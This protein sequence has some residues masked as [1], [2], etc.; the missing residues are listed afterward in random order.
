MTTQTSEITLRH[1]IQ[2]VATGP[3]YSK[4]LNLEEAHLAMQ[5][6]LDDSVDP[7][8]AAVFL[9][10]LR[11]KRE[12]QDENR[13]ALQ[14]IRETMDII[15][16]PVET[17]LDIADPY[18]G[19]LRHLPMSPFLPAVLASC[20]IPTF[21]HG[22][23]RVGPKYGVTHAKILRAAGINSDRT[24]S[25]AAQLLNDVGWAYV[26]QSRFCPALYKLGSLRTRIVKRP[27]LT[28]IEVLASPIRGKKSTH[29][30]TGYVHKAYP[31]IYLDLARR[32]SF[33]SAT[34]VKGN[35]GGI[36]PSLKQP[37][38]L[39]EYH[40]DS[41]MQPRELDPASCGL[42]QAVRAVP[43]PDDL[44]KAAEESDGIAASLDIDSMAA[45][46]AEVGIRALQGEK[47]IAL[48]SLIYGG[49]IILSHLRKQIS[50]SEAAKTIAKQIDSGEAYARFNAAL[51]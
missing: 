50:L 37:S 48:D 30:V 28:T 41:E 46:T 26:D 35:E 12:T 19:F 8:Q 43:V 13:G 20:K 23:E 17:V 10:A 27:L 47:G 1:C 25:D 29:Y 21:S 4:D 15:T 42:G 49:A 22:I 45:I 18:D 34:V 44:P 51:N 9:I 6:I 32:L 3:E 14:A 40:G 33:D 39:F 24:T 5:Q 2:K 31:P 16:A 7:V 11:M 36:I 38:R